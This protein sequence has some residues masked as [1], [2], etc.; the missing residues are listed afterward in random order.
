M[1]A[2]RGSARRE[3]QNKVVLCCLPVAGSPPARAA[4]SESGVVRCTTTPQLLTLYHGYQ[5]EFQKGEKGVRIRSI[6]G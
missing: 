5:S 6:I 2:P 1:R 3:R 4:A